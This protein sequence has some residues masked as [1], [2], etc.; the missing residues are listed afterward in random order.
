MPRASSAPPITAAALALALALAL[1]S[2]LPPPTAAARPP[3]VLFLMADQM[4]FDTLGDQYSPRLAALARRGLQLSNV[5][6]ATPSCTP[7][8]SALLTGLSPWYNGMLGY[9]DVA[10]RYPFEMPR[11]MGALGYET[12][13][14]GKNHYYNSEVMPNNTSPPPSH[15]WSAQFLYDGLGSGEQSNDPG[16]EFD[17]YDD[18]FART[19]GGK[20]PLATGKPLLDWNSWRAAPYVYDEALHPTAWVGAQA[21]AFLANVSARGPSAP[22]FFLKVSFH[23][24]HSPYDPPARLLNSTP[25]SGLPPVRVGAP[26][27]AVFALPPCGPQDAD[28]WCGAMPEA[29]LTLARRA[30]RANIRFVDEQVG[31]IADDLERLGLAN[32]TWVIFTSDH[33]DAQGD[34]NLFRKTYP[35]ECSAHVPGFITWPPSVTAAMPRGSVSPLL[36]ELRDVFATVLDIAGRGDLSR[37]LNGSSWACLVTADP[38]GATCGPGSGGG[39]GGGG[40]PRPWRETLDLEHSLIFGPRIHWNA[41]LAGPTAGPLAHLKYIFFAADATEQLFNLSSDPHEM[42]DLAP[43]PAFAAELAAL[44]GQLVAQF[45]RE[46]RGPAWVSASGKLLPRTTGQVYSPNYPPSTPPQP[47]I[48]SPPCAPPHWPAPGWFCTPPGTYFRSCGGEAGNLAP[49]SLQTVAAAQAWCCTNASCAGF[50]WS[51]S[52]ANASVGSGYY[53]TNALCGIA[54]NTSYSG[55]WKPGQVPGH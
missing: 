6:T 28:A 36:G 15:G 10:V 46:G 55:C 44:R 5:Y 13:A 49:L 2:C 11:E 3:N 19:T 39:S 26:W 37:P 18:W 51:P 7:A 4:R 14:V 33:G 12:V 34:H 32:D 27:D 8:R 48:P 9:G 20:D 30:Y 1:A 54:T 45:R 29:N 31:L 43:D 40:A 47:P 50:D 35:W 42:V 25:A 52:D 16:G 38:S 41:I 53:K 22:P 21:R 23:R 24:P 17:T